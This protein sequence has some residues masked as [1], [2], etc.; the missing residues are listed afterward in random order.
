MLR[1]IRQIPNLDRIWLGAKPVGLGR[2]AHG[3]GAEVRVWHGAGVA[4]C[5]RFPFDGEDGFPDV[6]HCEARGGGDFGAEGGAWGAGDTGDYV[7]GGLVGYVWWEVLQLG[8]GQGYCG[9]VD[10]RVC[11]IFIWDINADLP[12]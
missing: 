6:Y 7:V 11:V 4:E 2:D 5:E 8:Y 3:H 1:T 12:T 10:R 9:R